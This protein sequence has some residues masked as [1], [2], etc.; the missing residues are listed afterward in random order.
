M[1]S[2]SWFHSL[3][4]EGVPVDIRPAVGDHL[5]LW[6]LVFNGAGCR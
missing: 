3:M 2:G 6:P 1:L 4:A 5:G